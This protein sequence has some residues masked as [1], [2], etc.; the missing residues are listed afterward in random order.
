MIIMVV[1]IS[2]ELVVA[3]LRPRHVESTGAAAGLRR[4]GAGGA[5]CGMSIPVG[6]DGSQKALKHVQ[7]QRGCK[8]WLQVGDRAGWL[9]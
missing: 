3:A 5:K 2:G 9:M 7:M 6:S 8:M 4:L 1:Q